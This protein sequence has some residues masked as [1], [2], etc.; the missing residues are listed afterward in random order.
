MSF[1]EALHDKIS[2]GLLDSETMQELLQVKD[3]SLDQAITKCHGI[4]VAKKSQWDGH[5]RNTGG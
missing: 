3:L 5:P 2:E 1:P 4:E